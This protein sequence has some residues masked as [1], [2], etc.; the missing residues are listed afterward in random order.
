VHSVL[1]RVKV[2][3]VPHRARVA[4]VVHSVPRA[5]V[6]RSVLRRVQE[7]SELRRVPRPSALLLRVVCLEPVAAQAAHSALLRPQVVHLVQVLSEELRKAKADCLEPALRPQVP[8]VHRQV[9]HL[10]HLRAKV[11]SE[12]RQLLQVL[13]VAAWAAEWQLVEW[14]AELM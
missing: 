9:V 5:L 12:C 4:L 8:L 10:V 7:P 11:D 3:S 2:R 14:E 13:L 1:R 6:Q